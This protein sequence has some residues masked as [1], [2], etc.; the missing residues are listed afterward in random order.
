MNIK[1]SVVYENIYTREQFLCDDVNDTK[2]IDGQIYLNVKRPG[3]ERTFY[4]RKESLVKTKLR[5]K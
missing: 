3:T 2:I 5:S 4:I 1:N